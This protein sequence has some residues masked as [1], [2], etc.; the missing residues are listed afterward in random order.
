MKPNAQVYSKYL[1]ASP[2]VW[3]QTNEKFSRE[4]KSS[5]V[6]A[7]GSWSRSH[8]HG[9]ALAT[10]RYCHLSHS[11][12]LLAVPARAAHAAR[13]RQDAALELQ[14]RGVDDGRRRRAQQYVLAARHDADQG[15][16]ALGGVRDAAAGAVRH[17]QGAHA[18][19]GGRGVSPSLSLFFRRRRAL[20][21]RA[22]PPCCRV[23]R[24]C[25]RSGSWSRTPSTRPRRCRCATSSTAR[26]PASRRKTIS[27]SLRSV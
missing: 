9:L 25:R 23:R 4:A 18:G 2:S 16:A 24:L 3:R 1:L 6:S 17:H 11:R 21:E 26:C 19:R 7:F 13:P 5:R 22:A 8:G 15:L 20:A 10:R 12:S 27:R 14:Q